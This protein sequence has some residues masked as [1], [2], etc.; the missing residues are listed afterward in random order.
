PF[1]VGWF[2]SPLPRVAPNAAPPGAIHIGPLWGRFKY[3]FAQRLLVDNDTWT[4]GTS[5]GFMSRN[6]STL[7]EHFRSG[8]GFSSLH[9]FARW[10]LHGVKGRCVD[11]SDG[12]STCQYCFR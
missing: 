4:T 2:L 3:P 5:G 6:Q 12:I 8:E 7:R 10:N 11:K 1:R 9:S